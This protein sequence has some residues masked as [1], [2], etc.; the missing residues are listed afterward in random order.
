MATLIRNIHILHINTHIQRNNFKI[1]ISPL[2][3][4]VNVHESLEIFSFF[5]GKMKM[6]TVGTII[7][8]TEND[9]STCT[10]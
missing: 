9:N 3:N 1:H 5:I 6:I 4:C 8:C 2:I 7:Y 10:V